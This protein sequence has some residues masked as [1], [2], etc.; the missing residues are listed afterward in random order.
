MVSTC[1]PTFQFQNDEQELPEPIIIQ[2]KVPLDKAEMK[3]EK[4]STDKDEIDSF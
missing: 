3:V 4:K 1:V 2:P